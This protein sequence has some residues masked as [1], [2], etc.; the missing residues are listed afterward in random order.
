MKF[1]LLSSVFIQLVVS[2]FILTPEW[3]SGVQDVYMHSRNL[4]T[5]NLSIDAAKEFSDFSSAL[6]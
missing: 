2:F 3:N 1:S 5:G 6:G 4:V